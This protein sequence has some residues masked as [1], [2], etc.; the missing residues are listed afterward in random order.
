MY[1]NKPAIWKA[2][3]TLML[4]SGSPT[5]FAAIVAT[6]PDLTIEGIGVDAVGPNKFVRVS[7]PQTQCSAVGSSVM[8]LNSAAENFAMVNATLLTALATGKKVEIGHDGTT[9]CSIL[10]VWILK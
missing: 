6:I 10:R 2:C 9:Y 4:L 5:S 8:L 7:P 1:I 3:F